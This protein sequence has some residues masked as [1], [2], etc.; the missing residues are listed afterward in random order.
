M[1]ALEE[2]RAAEQRNRALMKAVPL[3]IRQLGPDGE[4]VLVN[5]RWCELPGLADDR[6]GVASSAPVST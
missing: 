2:P 1:T 6:A 4:R 5:R 3:G